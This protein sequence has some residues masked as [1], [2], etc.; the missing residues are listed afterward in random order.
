MM[1]LWAI[2]VLVVGC[3]L[4]L[5]SRAKAVAMLGPMIGAQVGG[6]SRSRARRRLALLIVAMAGIVVALAQPRW[7]YRWTELKQSGTHLVVVLDTSLSMDAQDVSPSRMER[8]HREIFDLAD[9]LSGDRVGL[10]LFSGG[11]YTRMPVTHDYGAL[12]T[13]VAR[14]NTQTLKSQGSDLGAAIRMAT[15]VVGAGENA[16]R[17]MIIISDGE[18]QVGNAAEAAKAAIA[19]GVHIFVVGVGTTDGAPIPLASGGFKK[20]KSGDLVLTRIDE[21]TLKNIAKIGGGAYVRSVAGSADMRALYFDEILSK[22]KREEQISRREKVWMERFQW[23]LGLAWFAALLGFLIRGRRSVVIGIA[24]F[25]L[26]LYSPSV[27]ASEDTI[28]ALSAEQISSPDDLGV[29]ERLGA[30]LFG[31]GQFNKA[32]RVLAAVAERHTDPEARARARYNSGLAAYKAGSLTTALESWQRVLQDHPDHAAA[33]KN[34]KA[35]SEEIQKRM[36]EEPPPQEGEG[37]GDAQDKDA[38]SPPEEATDTGGAPDDGTREP[39]PP[40]TED[41][42]LARPSDPEA[43]DDADGAEGADAEEVP[44]APTELKEISATEAA[45]MFDAVKEGDPRVVI[46]PGSR[47]GG[48]W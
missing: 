19:A 29:A 44:G 32:G 18:D 9:M 21:D 45:R 33:Q 17:A 15:A 47:G 4:A 48:E 31:A 36:G 28:S 42:G 38:D 13:M 8:A 11:A 43:A 3:V 34:A 39:S 27:L 16:D 40:D 12:R 23:P 41:T 14:S 24:L 20:D 1:A 25:A 2:P 5:R 46:D 7:G 6:N 30:A 37:D 10:V 22:L 26:T 35:V